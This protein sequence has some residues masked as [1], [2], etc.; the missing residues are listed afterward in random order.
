V[1]SLTMFA[2]IG[3]T[4][5][6][7]IG[8]DGR[9]ISR[10]TDTGVKWDLMSADSVAIS[11]GGR[12]HFFAFPASTGTMITAEP[13]AHASGIRCVRANQ[14]TM[15]SKCRFGFI[16]ANGDLTVCR[17]LAANQRLPPS[18]EAQKIA[19]F[20]DEF[21]WHSVHGVVLAR[22]HAKLTVWCAPSQVFFTAAAVRRGR[23]QRVR[24]DARVCNFEGQGV[25][26]FARNGIPSEKAFAIRLF[27][28]TYRFLL[29]ARRGG[30][31][32]LK[33]L[34]PSD[35]FTSQI[36]SYSR[37]VGVVAHI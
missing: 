31:S 35:F 16:N 21:V 19:N 24:R 26:R 32:Y 8:H 37:H 27:H 25:L 5:V 4:V 12:K 22:T 11:P 33:K 13:F 17:F 2:F 30:G 3:S 10:I 15:Q 29:K 34:F 36:D 20:V 6:Q 14:A 28:I 23:D 18:I 9:P 1:Q 7:I